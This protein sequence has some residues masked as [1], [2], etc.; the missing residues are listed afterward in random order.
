MAGKSDGTLVSLSKDCRK[1][2]WKIAAHKGS[3]TCL[4]SG[5][6]YF[7]S[8]G[9]DCVVRM[10][11]SSTRQMI[12]QISVH[13]KPISGVFGDCNAPHVIHSCSLDRSMHA[14]DMK[15]DKKLSF[16]QVPAGTLTSMDQSPS[17]GNIGSFS[18]I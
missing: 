3:V 7:L 10:W 15:S 14:Y 4:F 11:A 8:G 9:E 2:N 17:S 1:T 12:N 16:K 13:Q 6:N 18:L 5:E